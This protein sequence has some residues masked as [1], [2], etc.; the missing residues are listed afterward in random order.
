MNGS[1]IDIS[2]AVNEIVRDYVPGTPDRTSLKTKLIEIKI[3]TDCLKNNFSY[4]KILC[5]I[6]IKKIIRKLRLQIIPNLYAGV[7]K[8]QIKV[9]NIETK[10]KII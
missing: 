10:Q 1:S 6:G 5:H 2:S 7:F 3:F 4:K 9:E 8:N